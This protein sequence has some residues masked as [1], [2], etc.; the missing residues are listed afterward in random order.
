LFILLLSPFAFAQNLNGVQ[1]NDRTLIYGD[2]YESSQN[3]KWIN[4]KKKD[5]SIET[6]RRDDVLKFLN[7]EN[8]NLKLSETSA[9][10]SDMVDT[11]QEKI[12]IHTFSCLRSKSF[13]LFKILLSG[14]E[15]SCNDGLS[16]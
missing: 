13:L 4:I 14:T 8:G 15:S 12:F 2:V 10:S 16:I 1:L 6:I 11:C 5:G 3:S 9:P 7:N